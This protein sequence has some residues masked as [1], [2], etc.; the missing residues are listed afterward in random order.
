MQF[1]VAIHVPEN[2][3]SRLGFIG[4][5]GRSPKKALHHSAG[6][7]C[8]WLYR[9]RVAQRPLLKGSSNVL[10]SPDVPESLAGCRVFLPGKMKV[11][12]P[13]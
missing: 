1:L 13:A 10:K 9:K 4:N 6:C 11:V 2:F 3:G 5:F 8:Q 12:M 7:Q